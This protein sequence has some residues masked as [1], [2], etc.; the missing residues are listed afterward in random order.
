MG[1]SADQREAY[2]GVSAMAR[3]HRGPNA[4]ELQLFDHLWFGLP[5]H[6]LEK[7]D[8]LPRETSENVDQRLVRWELGG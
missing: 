3:G 6:D 1:S 8:I 4:G 7:Q 2:E 5:R